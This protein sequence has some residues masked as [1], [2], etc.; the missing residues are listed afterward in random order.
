MHSWCV[1]LCLLKVSGSLAADAGGSGSELFAQCRG[2]SRAWAG[3]LS[4][5]GP[6]WRWVASRWALLPPSFSGLNEVGRLQAGQ[7]NVAHYLWSK[8]KAMEIFILT[9][10]MRKMAFGPFTIDVNINKIF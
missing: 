4:R 8:V 3:E 1:F 2:G 9:G 10:V 5:T 7:S 6:F